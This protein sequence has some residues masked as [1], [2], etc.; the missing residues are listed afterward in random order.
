ML[1]EGSERTSFRKTELIRRTLRLHLREV[2]EAETRSNVGQLTAV[3]PWPKGALARAYRR[4]GTEW[5]KMESAASA[6]QG[7]PGWDD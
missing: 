1:A 6:A 4:T 7:R 3:A 2:I 5:D